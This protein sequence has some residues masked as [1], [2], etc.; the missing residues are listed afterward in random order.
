M[1]ERSQNSSMS[2]PYEQAFRSY[3]KIRALRE[4]ETGCPPDYNYVEPILV[5]SQ[6]ASD[7][8]AQAQAPFRALLEAHRAKL[9]H[10]PLPAELLAEVEEWAGRPLRPQVP[11]LHVVDI[12]A[13]TYASRC[14]VMEKVILHGLAS[15]YPGGAPVSTSS[16]LQE[17]RTKE[18]VSG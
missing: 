13:C 2:N 16:V 14:S 10:P 15:L 5:G 11:E 18:V 17:C 12:R 3:L 9:I 1:S 4:G 6:E 7:M 8:Q